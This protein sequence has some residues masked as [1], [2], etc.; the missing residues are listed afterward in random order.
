MFPGKKLL[1]M[2]CE[3]GQS[4]EWDA[5]SQL[6]WWL[7]EAGPYHQGLQRFVRDLNKVYL[8]ERGLWSADFD[9]RGFY[10]MDCSDRDKSVLS[11]VR[12]DGQLLGEM[13]VILNL[14]PMPRYHYRIGLP[15]SGKWI[16]ALNSDALI[17]GG[18]NVG[19]LGGVM[20]ES[21]KC[22]NQPWSAEFT[23]P[24]LSLVAFRPE[25]PRPS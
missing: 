3:F 10:W 11:F 6:D 18:S 17:Y 13:L 1:F 16:E 22:H 24:P 25:R 9:P 23:L 12:Q 19:N 7:L 15:R 2:G 5:N 21:H 4:G 20:A 8:A 14:T